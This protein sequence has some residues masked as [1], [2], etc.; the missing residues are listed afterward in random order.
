MVAMG[1]NVHWL[2]LAS[3]GSCVCAA[4]AAENI[5]SEVCFKIMVAELVDRD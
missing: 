2:N 5:L 3:T 4:A 1:C